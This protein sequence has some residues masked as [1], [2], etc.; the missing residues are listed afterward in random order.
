MKLTFQEFAKQMYELNNDPI[1]EIIQEGWIYQVGDA[2]KSGKNVSDRVLNC[3][4]E[5]CFDQ[6][7][8]AHYRNKINR[9]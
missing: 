9:K 3:H 8:C 6:T 2:I 7:G 4:N 1:P 5:I